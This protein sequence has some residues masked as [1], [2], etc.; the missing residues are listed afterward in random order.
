MRTARRY[1]EWSLLKATKSFK[2]VNRASV[3]TWTL[4]VQEKMETETLEVL[5][6]LAYATP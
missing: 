6:N 4:R 5:Q 1:L 2:T 3:S